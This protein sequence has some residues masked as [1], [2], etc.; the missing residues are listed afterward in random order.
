[1]YITVIGTAKN[2]F[3]KQ[4]PT[5]SGKLL[6]STTNI[7][8]LRY[9]ILKNTDL[10][11]GGHKF[12]AVFTLPE[13]LPASFSFRNNAASKFNLFRRTGCAIKYKVQLVVVRANSPIKKF[14][15]PFEVMNL[16]DLNDIAPSL[17]R[18]RESRST[19]SNVISPDFYMSASVPQR[20]YVPG[21]DIVV[22]V[23]ARNLSDVNIKEIEISLIKKIILTYVDEKDPNE[24][25][26]EEWILTEVTEECEE[27]L[28][29]EQKE[30]RKVL[31]VPQLQPAIDN[32][33]LIQVCYRIWV[34]A[35]TDESAMRR[36]TL[37]I[38]IVIGSVPLT[39]DGDGDENKE[40]VKNLMKAKLKL[41]LNAEVNCECTC[42][43]RHCSKGKIGG[44]RNG[45]SSSPDDLDTPMIGL[46]PKTPLSPTT[47][48][49]FVLPG[50]SVPHAV[51]EV[52]EI[53]VK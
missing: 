41:S 42:T 28:S 12:Q 32:C 1:V 20:G 46:M 5:G 4:T 37:V 51:L 38:P 27:V 18:P 31:R 40:N 22:S 36:E 8:N 29:G 47:P 52:D 10:P 39:S 26:E 33:K 6:S 23:T 44:Y 30:F 53:E 48:G 49:V 17:K 14:D 25:D 21:D 3:L 15:Y 34:K 19:T 9:E 7:L 43:C 13:D 11:T 16:V 50:P 24:Q 35:K 45:G 2:K